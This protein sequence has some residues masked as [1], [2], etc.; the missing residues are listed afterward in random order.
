L[1][2]IHRI[3]AFELKDG[4][5]TSAAQWGMLTHEN[6]GARPKPRWN[7]YLFLNKLIGKRLPLEGNGSWVSGVAS[8]NDKEIRVLLVN[9]DPRQKHSEYVPIRIHNLAP[10]RYQLSLDYLFGKDSRLIKE[11]KED[12]LFHQVYLSVN[13]AVFITLSPLF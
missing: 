12:T 2:R 3:F 5:G 4:P 6:N 10:G 8:K 11:T 9:Y 13:E 1:N 7:A